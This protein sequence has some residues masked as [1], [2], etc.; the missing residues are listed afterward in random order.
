MAFHRHTSGQKE[1]AKIH[2]TMAAIREG[3]R[4]SPVIFSFGFRAPATSPVGVW[5]SFPLMWSAQTRPLPV[6]CEIHDGE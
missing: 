1:E 5:L 2:H 4:R 3:L 6:H